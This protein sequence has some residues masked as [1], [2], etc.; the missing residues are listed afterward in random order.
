MAA[1]MPYPDPASLDLTVTG[2][3]D[4]VA[5]TGYWTVT[6]P[7]DPNKVHAIIERSKSPDDGHVFYAWYLN[8]RTKAEHNAQNA[9]MDTIDYGFQPSYE[10]ALEDLREAWVEQVGIGRTA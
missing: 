7:Q 9:Y 3:D 6:G 10:A 8:R 5:R 1:E 4:D 2:G